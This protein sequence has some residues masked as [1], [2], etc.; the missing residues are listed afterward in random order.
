MTNVSYTDFKIESKGR[1]YYLR[2][3]YEKRGA[4][5]TLTI[6]TQRGGKGSKK[7]GVTGTIAT[8]ES[9]IELLHRLYKKFKFQFVILQNIPE[10]PK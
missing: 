5:M 6:R 1:T 3:K 10:L 2:K 7:A 9:E 4:R 8:G